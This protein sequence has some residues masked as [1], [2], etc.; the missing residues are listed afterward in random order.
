MNE[1]D[2]ICSSHHMNDFEM[3]QSTQ[4]HLHPEPCIMLG[5][6]S[7][8]LPPSNTHPLLPGSGTSLQHF[9]EQHPGAT[10]Y[11]MTPYPPHHHP[12]TTPDMGVPTGPNFYNPYMNPASSARMFPAPMNHGSSSHITNGV[13]VDDYGRSADGF[14]GPYKRKTA[15]GIVGNPHYLNTYAGPSSS[16][17]PVRDSHHDSGITVMDP[18]FA[19]PENRSN[20]PPSILEAGMQSNVR[21]R[22]GTVGPESFMPHNYLNLPQRNYMIPS[23]QPSGGS[24]LEQ[25]AINNGGDGGS[26]SWNRPAIFPYFQGPSINGGSFEI[27]DVTAPGYHDTPSARPPANFMHSPPILH[28]HHTH[29]PPHSIPSTRGYGVSFHP[30]AATSS[31]LPTNTAI[32][33]G[34]VSDFQVGGETAPPTGIRIYRSHRRGMFPDAVSRHRNLPHL[35]HLPED[36]V[37]ILE[38]PAY[39]EV[40]NFVDHHSDMRLDIDDMSYEELLA[41][42]EQIGTVNTGL[43]EEAIASHLKT[44]RYCGMSINLEELPC[45]DQKND[46]CIICQDEYQENDKVGTL[47][48]G[49]DYHA[50]CL[51]PWLLV[52]NSCPIC[53]LTAL[54]INN[55]S[56]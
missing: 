7:G 24:W 13:P 51:K 14:R 17:P 15:E 16:V 1:R 56:G 42:S 20:G 52:K 38:F 34:S 2:M 10:F 43:S 9:Q 4:S 3:D 21:N 55:K 22:R 11:G 23:F 47:D 54:D 30:M 29:H 18:S 8:A 44:R 53:K 41:L 39:Y 49:H 32:Q 28:Q 35:R 5:S 12:T 45:I 50:D 36:E 27:G 46:S 37:A 26:M 33:H 40:G 19:L 25:Q 48:C 31:R 6:T